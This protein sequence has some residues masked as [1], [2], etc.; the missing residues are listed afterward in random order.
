MSEATPATAELPRRQALCGIIALGVLGPTALAACSTVTKEYGNQPAA[1]KEN[2][3]PGAPLAKL[4]SVP[5]GG[6]TVVAAPD[7][8]QIVVIQPAPG[9]VRAYNASCTHQGTPVGAPD[10]N[11]VM[12][13]PNHNS[14]F[15]AKDGSVVNGPATSPLQEVSVKLA[16]DA[17]V[18]A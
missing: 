16:G 6:G 5:V 15:Q 12:T 4:A 14:K 18:L 7:G 2:T 1:P 11:G 8:R 3:N 17:I 13:C 9:E 10:A